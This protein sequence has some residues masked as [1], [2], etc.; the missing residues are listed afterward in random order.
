MDLSQFD[1]T[2]IQEIQ[3][4]FV[5]ETSNLK[6]IEK[7]CMSAQQHCRM[8]G[9]VGHA[10]YGKT[11]SLQYYAS[12]Q[13]NV[14]YFVVPKSAS[15]KKIY[16]HLLNIVGFSSI[17]FKGTDLNS[18]IMGLSHHLNQS[19]KKNL[20]ICDEAGKFNHHQLLYL[21]ELRDNT[22]ASTGIVLVGPPYF[23]SNLEDWTTKQKEGIPELWRRIQ[24]WI[25]LNAPSMEEKRA[26][27]LESGIIGN[28]LIHQ[29]CVNN[30]RLDQIENQIVEFKLAAQEYL[31][32]TATDHSNSIKLIESD[33]EDDHKQVIKKRKKNLS[34]RR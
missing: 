29:L 19:G 17:S 21:H 32:E 11:K 6:T 18:L 34:S 12:Q 13:R 24:T 30:V 8:I 33:K 10:G 26:F 5:L 25:A 23:R 3:Q 14:Y 4:D 20:L 16:F 7:C 1:L 2:K 15:P 9:I 28:E 22:K 31:Q 27:C